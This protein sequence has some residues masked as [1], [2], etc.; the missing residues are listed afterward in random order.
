MKFTHFIFNKDKLP[1]NTEKTTVTDCCFVSEL[2][3][4]V[5]YLV[6]IG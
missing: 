5:Y 6:N 2:D 4:Y 1:I 3:L